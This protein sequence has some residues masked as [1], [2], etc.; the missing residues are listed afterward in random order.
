MRLRIVLNVNLVT[1]R[2]ILLFLLEMKEGTLKLVIYTI[3]QQRALFLLS[4]Y[5]Q[6]GDC[7]GKS[8]S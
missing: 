5:Y 3:A 1:V 2:K 4:Q 6:T 7:G 8:D